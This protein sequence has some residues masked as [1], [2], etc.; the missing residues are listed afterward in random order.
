MNQ[1][2]EIYDS[3]DSDTYRQ[4][5]AMASQLKHGQKEWPTNRMVHK[6]NSQQPEWSIYQLSIP[7]NKVKLGHSVTSLSLVIV[8]Y[9][10]LKNK[11]DTK[12]MTGIVTGSSNNDVHRNSAI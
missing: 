12:M 7:M 5:L 3:G 1:S 9:S 6:L 8:S 11:A 4:V 10:W 2:N